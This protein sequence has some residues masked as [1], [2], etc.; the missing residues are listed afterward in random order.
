MPLGRVLAPNIGVVVVRQKIEYNS[1]SPRWDD[2]QK[3]D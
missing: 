2:A 1:Q 3:N